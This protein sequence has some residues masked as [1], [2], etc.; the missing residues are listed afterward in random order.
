[1]QWRHLLHDAE[2]AD[3]LRMAGF[4][5]VYPEEHS[6]ADQV[7]LF[8]EAEVIVSPSGSLLLNL[9]FA[10][11]SVKLLVLNQGHLFSVNGF[12]GPMRALGYEP[13]FLCGADGDPVDRHSS[14]TI[15]L[16]RLRE[17]TATDR[18][19]GTESFVRIA[20][21]HSCRSADAGLQGPDH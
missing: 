21:S 11:P 14:F 19:V 13:H 6:F 4:E 7:R 12:Y 1:M 20:E 5:I 15:P 18:A 8:Q 10:D 17:G 9:I 16:E 2:I 3:T